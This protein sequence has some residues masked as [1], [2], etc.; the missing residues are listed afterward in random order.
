M[1]GNTLHHTRGV[2]IALGAALVLGLV[3]IAGSAEHPRG[4]RGARGFLSHGLLRDLDLSD[5]QRERIR[6]ILDETESTGVQRRSREAHRSLREAIENGAD[7]ESLR[8]LGRELGEAE[9]EAAI[10]RASIHKR[11]LSVLTDEQRQEL[12]ALREEAREEMEER[13][14][15]LEERRQRRP[16]KNPDL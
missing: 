3:T 15:R 5:A 16:E 13:Q 2:L 7:D 4:P 6:G 10:E 9:G 1:T 8:E 14:K 12:E 11:I